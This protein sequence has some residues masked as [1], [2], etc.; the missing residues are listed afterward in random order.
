VS[1]P[2]SLPDPTGAGPNAA[3]NVHD[4]GVESGIQR[5]R[6]M[7]HETHLLA[8]E[9]VVILARDLGAM[10]TRFGEIAE[11]GDAYPIGVRELCSR[12]ADELNLQAQSMLGIMDRAQR[13]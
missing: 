12:L 2:D 1:E 7:Q 9:Q 5:V 10:A 8:Q 6:R 13:V 4:L 11:G 3:G